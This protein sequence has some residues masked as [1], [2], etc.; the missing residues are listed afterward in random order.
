MFCVNLNKNYPCQPTDDLIQRVAMKQVTIVLVGFDT[1]IT[2]A[3]PVESDSVEGALNEAF[4][5]SQH[6]APESFVSFN[7]L[8]IRSSSVGDIF[9]ID[10]RNFIVNRVG[11]VEV[12][13]VVAIAWQKIPSR[14]VSMGWEWC[15][16]EINAVKFGQNTLVP[17]V[18]I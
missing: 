6:D 4:T 12:S 10:G 11:F 7:R 5:K 15:K 13:T 18:E 16:K 14:D 17:L 3:L 2:Y 1:R 8:P 9:M